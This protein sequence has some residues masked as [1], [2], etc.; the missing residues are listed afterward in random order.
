MTLKREAP[1]RGAAQ[2]ARVLAEAEAAGSPSAR[3][4]ATLPAWA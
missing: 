3:C 4:N 1:G 2:V